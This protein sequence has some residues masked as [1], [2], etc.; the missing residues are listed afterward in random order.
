MQ[1]AELDWLTLKALRKV[2]DGQEKL[3]LAFW[4]Y[5]I[6]GQ[7]LLLF[8]ALLFALVFVR[9]KYAGLLIGLS[10]LLA[11]FIWSSIGVWRCA[12]N[13]KRKVWGYLA[14]VYVLVQLYVTGHG[15]IVY[16]ARNAA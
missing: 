12:F 4:G 6:R 11:W 3:Y 8:P 5:Y 1:I 9:F 16:F 13:V 10:L 7:L 15:L 2:W 14:R